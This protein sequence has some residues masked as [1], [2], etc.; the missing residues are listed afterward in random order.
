MTRLDEKDIRQKTM[1]KKTPMVFRKFFSVII[2]ILLCAV[3]LVV[4]FNFFVTAAGAASAATV[5]TKNMLEEKYGL[6]V[7]LLAVTAAGGMVD[8]RLKVID[9][10]K[11]RLLLQD[12]KN[13]P[14]LLA[15][16]RKNLLNVDEDTK[17]QEIKFD[18]NNGIFLM[19]PNSGNIVRPGSPVVVVFGDIQLEAVAAR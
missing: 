6:R 15:G 10:E 7:N 5:I 3:G 12:K 19:F 17:S 9:G 16:E 11:A 8:L 18:P 14:A 13:F 1:N 2:M 4:Y